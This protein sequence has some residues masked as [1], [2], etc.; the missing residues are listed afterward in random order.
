[1]NGP[2]EIK[3]KA[4][5]DIKWVD[6]RPQSAKQTLLKLYTAENSTDN[7]TISL[8][9]TSYQILLKMHW[10]I[11]KLTLLLNCI[12]ISNFLIGQNFLQPKSLRCEYVNNPLGIDISQPRFTW[13]FTDS[14]Q[15]NK[16]QSAYEIIVSSNMNEI[17]KMKGN[18]WTSGKIISNE[19]VN[20]EYEG[21]SVTTFYPVLLEIKSG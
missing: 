4:K 13:N 9:C 20:V 15:R 8:F 3:I 5:R 19:N 12:V 11:K 1:M 16:S 2:V 21:K 6:V 10:Y 7:A 14:K 18:E 17:Q